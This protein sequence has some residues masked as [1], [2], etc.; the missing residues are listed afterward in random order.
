[1]LSRK[2]K[3]YKELASFVII[4]ISKKHRVTFYNITDTNILHIEYGLG[5]QFN[6]MYHIDLDDWM[7]SF[8]IAKIKKLKSKIDEN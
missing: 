1:M 2:V 6:T 7:E 5:R 3:L 4:E 8:R